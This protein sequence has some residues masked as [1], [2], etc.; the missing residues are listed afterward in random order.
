M[1]KSMNI[2]TI[3]SSSVISNTSASITI[4]ASIMAPATLIV[5]E[6]QGPTNQVLDAVVD[7]L[8]NFDE[9]Q[10]NLSILKSIKV[11]SLKIC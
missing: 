11:F 4:T 1:K 6:S 5:G 8:P 9:F 10:K 3:C 7:L 2:F